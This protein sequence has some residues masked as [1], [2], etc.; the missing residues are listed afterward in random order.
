MF[1]PNETDISELLKDE[2]KKND[3]DDV[4]TSHNSGLNNKQDL[5]MS[6]QDINISSIFGLD[7][8][9][10]RLLFN[11][12]S[13]LRKSYIILD[14]R[15]RASESLDRTTT[16]WNF[17]TD[18]NTVQGSVNALGSI[19][20]I[21]AIKI[22]DLWLPCDDKQSDTYPIYNGLIP[23]NQTEVT[24]LIP[25][26]QVQSYVAPENRRFHFWGTYMQ[27]LQSIQSNNGVNMYYTP[28]YFNRGSDVIGYFENYYRLQDGNNGIFEFSPPITTLNTISLNFGN[29]YQLINMPQDTYEFIFTGG[30]NTQTLMYFQITPNIIANIPYNMTTF[31]YISD[32]N[33]DQPVEDAKLISLLNNP[34]GFVYNV[35]NSFLN[36]GYLQLTIPLDSDAVFPIMVG[37]QISGTIYLDYFRY[38][39]GLEITYKAT[40]NDL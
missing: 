34:Q 15:F 5:P 28:V 12:E 30:P 27:Q 4:D 36:N 1:E 17:Q 29:P 14:R 39:V 6:Q 32:F 16:T 10:A 24:V 19:R 18:A 40:T 31:G 13:G 22:L 25:E 2:I 20:D 9:K 38:Y 37:N 33:T 3:L 11:P 35:S 23:S 7:I 8:D 26:L 21:T